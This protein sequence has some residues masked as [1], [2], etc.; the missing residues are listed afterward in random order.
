MYQQTEVASGGPLVRARINRF[1]NSGSRLPPQDSPRSGVSSR[2]KLIEGIR[3]YL[4]LWVL[5]CHVLWMSGY[6]EDVLS[7]PAKLLVQGGCAVDVFIIISGFV[8]FFVL[9]KQKEGW[10]PFL[11]RRFF[12]LFPLFMVM[13]LAAIAVSRLT[14]CNVEYLGTH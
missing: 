2:L 14:S 3:A 1:R 5:V 4:A 12:R 8:I 10:Q 6:T 9:D 13:F 7:G 11:I